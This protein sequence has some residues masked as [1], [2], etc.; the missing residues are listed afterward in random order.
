MAKTIKFNLM[1]DGYPCR[2]IEDVKEHFCIEDMLE[3]Y[4]SGLLKRWLEVRGF[5]DE[6]AEVEAIKATEVLQ[7]TEELTRIFEV[8]ADEEEIK[9]VLALINDQKSCQNTDQ[10]NG[11]GNYQSSTIITNYVLG[12]DSIVKEMMDKSTPSKVVQQ[13]INTLATDYQPLFE[14]NIFSLFVSS[15]NNRPLACL[16]LLFNDHSR[17]FLV[18]RYSSIREF[19]SDNPYDL[20]YLNNIIGSFVKKKSKAFQAVTSAN[21]PFILFNSIKEETRYN[22]FK[23]LPMLFEDQIK[24]AVVKQNETSDIEKPGTR[25]LPLFFNEP[26]YAHLEVNGDWLRPNDAAPYTITNGLKITAR[27]GRDV[28]VAYFKVD[29]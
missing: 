21:F 8:L 11:Q 12:Y 28:A 5:K 17:K 6:L 2:N 7:I 1:C 24:I 13:H 3:Y 22:E 27:W 15:L 4:E 23:D 19:N 10:A 29:D 26:A 25:C 14:K 9:E 16:N 18:P 20:D